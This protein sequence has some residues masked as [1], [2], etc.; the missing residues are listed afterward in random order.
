MKFGYTVAS[1]FN[2]TVNLV[3][4]TDHLTDIIVENPDNEHFGQENLN[5]RKKRSYALSPDFSRQFPRGM[6]YYSSNSEMD[7]SFPPAL[8]LNLI[9]YLSTSWKVRCIMSSLYLRI[10]HK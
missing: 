8:S 3:S 2:G 9:V 5:T 7:L 4:G 1:S 6:D 10:V